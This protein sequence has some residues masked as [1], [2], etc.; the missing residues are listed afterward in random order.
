MATHDR[1]TRPST[2]AV[3]RRRSFTLLWMAQFIST[4]GNG[5]TAIAA[6]I[7]VYRLTG[8][9]LSVGMMLLATALPGLFIG[10][11]AGVVV[12]RFDRK[13]I[14]IAA[15]LICAV[16]SAAIPLVLPFGI[17]WLYALVA[18]SSA[19]GQLFAPAQASVLPETA[20]DDE[21]AAAN[22]MMTISQY[23]ALTIGYAGAGLIA[24]RASITWAFYLD[25]LSFAVSALCIMLIRVAPL[26]ANQVTNLTAVARNL[27]AGLGFVRD[28]AVLRSLVLMFVP[29]FISFGFT[30]ALFLPFTTRALGATEFQYGVLEAAFT[31]GFVVGSLMLAKLTDRLHAG[32]WIAVSFLGMGVSTIG[33]ALAWSVPFAIVC[34][35][36]VGLL[37][38]PSYLARQLLIQRTTPREMRGRVSSVFFVTR[39]TG[40]ML[41]MGA[42][43]LA[44][45]FD[46]RLLLLFSALVLI[47]CG[48]LALILPGIGQPSAEWR[49]ILAM[50][51]AGP[52]PSGLG[53]GRAARAADVDLLSFHLPGLSHLNIQERQHLAANSR[54]YEAQA[55]TAVVRQG[56][57][58]NMAYFVLNGRAVASRAEDG[59]DR[60]LEIHNPGDFFGEIAALTS[61][62]RT[63]SVVAEQPTTLL[64]VPAALLRTLARD[65]QLNRLFLSK[66][67]ERML[68]TNSV[69]LPRFAGFAQES[70][71]ELR[72]PAPQPSVG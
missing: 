2:F 15:S 22:A 11:I 48:A 25:A 33:M 68:R 28:T 7:L 54:V 18:L 32:Q 36:M 34:T 10:L 12:D 46:V 13:R 20:P 19:V 24:A 16:L 69:E 58:N 8:S 60:F 49:R 70:L 51:R 14:M 67:T 55:G 72:T 53:L 27:R 39:D 31:V 45:V 65:P 57:Q 9:A 71:R 41:G 29:V 23:G 50:L 63:A 59:V 42:V 52:S 4:I 37:N 62:P 66:M 17:G 35:A 61:L 26:A 1:S 64:E 6:S 44:D 21:L 47:G 30:N 43:G 5:L 56:E 38:A 40:F 3:F